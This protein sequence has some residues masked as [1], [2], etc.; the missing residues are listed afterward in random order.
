MVNTAW[1]PGLM[2]VAAEQYPHRRFNPLNREWVLVLPQRL[3]RPWV[4]LDERPPL[5]QLPPYDPSCSL[6]P[7]N[8]RSNNKR[9]PAYTET[10]VFNND[11][12]SLVLT[13]PNQAAN[14]NPLL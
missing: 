10:F 2:G 12:P 3:Q 11:Y 5:E 4:G 7:G 6:C 9:N 14:P 13:N 1:S 8:A